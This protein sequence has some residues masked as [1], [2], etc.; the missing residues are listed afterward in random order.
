MRN[1]TLLCLA[2]L[3]ITGL[4]VAGSQ[5]LA[6]DYTTIVLSTDVARPV[7][8]VWKDVGGFCDI[9]A[10]MKM[11][12][13]YTSGNGGLGTV[14]TLA[15]RVNEVMVGQT[16]HSYTYTQQPVLKDMY[17]ATVDVEPAGPGQS[18]IFYRIVYDQS[19]L[20][21]GQTKEKYREQH[22]R[23]F[24]GALAQMKKRVEGSAADQ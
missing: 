23:M 24:T 11:K 6:A 2:A 16:A 10:F 22:I 13:T 4:A 12:C 14:R 17:H 15:G 9:G 3:G 21:P 19:N 5:A 1:R 18:K 20:A 8:A 7:A